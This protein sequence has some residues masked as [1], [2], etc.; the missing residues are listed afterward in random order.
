MEDLD[1]FTGGVGGVKHLVMQLVDLGRRDMAISGQFKI[2]LIYLVHLWR[3]NSFPP[4]ES[5]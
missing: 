1:R 2:A 5:K 3:R 4:K